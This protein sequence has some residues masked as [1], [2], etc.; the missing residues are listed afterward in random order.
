[1]LRVVPYQ[2]AR[3]VVSVLVTKKNK[4]ITENKGNTIIIPAPL[5]MV[6]QWGNKGNSKEMN[7]QNVR[8][9]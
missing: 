8:Y 7:Q 9:G 6:K 3:A 2:L 5:A 4:E 1:M